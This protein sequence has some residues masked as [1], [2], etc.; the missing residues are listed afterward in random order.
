HQARKKLNTFC[1]K[2]VRSE[3]AFRVPLRTA[4]ALVTDGLAIWINRGKDIRLSFSRLAQ[5]R[6][7]SVKIDEAFLNAYAAGERWARNLFDNAWD[8][9]AQATKLT[10]TPAQIHASQEETRSFTA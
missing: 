2:A 5:L 7:R 6:D 8:G 9:K 10:W 1:P 3:P 4:K